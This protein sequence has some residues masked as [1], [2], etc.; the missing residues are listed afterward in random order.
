M[1]WVGGSCHCGR[2]KYRADVGFDDPT[3]R[4]NCS[5][6]TK[7]RA[8]ILPLDPARLVVESGLDEAGIYT[9]GEG[10]IE[11]IF[12]RTCGSKPLVQRPRD[13]KKRTARS[14][15]TDLR[16]GPYASL[17]DGVLGAAPDKQVPLVGQGCETYRLDNPATNAVNSSCPA[18]HWPSAAS[19]PRCP[20]LSKIFSDASQPRQSSR[21]FA[22]GR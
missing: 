13:S 14:G 16:S 4:C 7:S 17:A 20:P 6:C 10:G 15:T 19:L 5:I 11:H 12:C 18:S 3:F 8:W 9:F 2:I 21:D 1:A 22:S